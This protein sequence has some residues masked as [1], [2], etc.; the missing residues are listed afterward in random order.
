MVQVA[1]LISMRFHNIIYLKIHFRDETFDL[2]CIE[3]IGRGGDM[4][5]NELTNLNCEPWHGPGRAGPEPAGYNERD[6]NLAR[7]Q[8]WPDELG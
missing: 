3:S 7:S 6:L 4:L 8:V 5:P 2:A 1:S